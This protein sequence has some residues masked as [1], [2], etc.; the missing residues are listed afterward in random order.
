M[1]WRDLL[2]DGY[3][4]IGEE[5]T[6]ILGGLEVDMLD[7]MPSLD[8]NSIGWLAWHISR[9]QDA[10]VSAL[11]GSEQLWI[12]EGWHARFNRPKNAED[13]GFG[14]TPADV[15]T[16]RS[17]EPEVILSYYQ[18]VALRTREY[19]LSLTEAEFSRELDEPRFQPPPIVGVRI[20]SI[21]ADGLQHTG[22]MAYARGLL[23]GKGWQSY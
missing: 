23:Q 6:R 9:S 15:T 5:M 11:A 1:Q 14:H 22:Q 4:R 19:I 10:Q 13:S 20:V 8:T 2:L 7:T 21:M 3:G 18:A 16:F 17:P 12:T